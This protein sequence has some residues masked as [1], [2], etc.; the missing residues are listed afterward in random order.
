MKI[1]KSSL[2]V[3][4]IVAAVMPGCASYRTD[5]NISSESLPAASSSTKVLISE[6]S[7]PDRKYQVIGPIEV[8]VKKLTLFHSDPTKEQANEALTEKAR[9]IGADAVVNVTYQSGI[10]FTTWGYMDA[11]GTGVKLADQTKP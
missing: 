3:V 7:L 8:S 6:D 4:M 11:K 1:R 2:L 10:G 5:S 9:A